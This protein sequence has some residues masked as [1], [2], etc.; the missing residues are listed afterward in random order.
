LAVDGGGGHAGVGAGT[1]EGRG[2]DVGETA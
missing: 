1:V 2:T